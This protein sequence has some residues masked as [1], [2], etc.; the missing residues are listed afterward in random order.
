VTGINN[1]GAVVG[2]AFPPTDPTHEQ[3]LILIGSKYAFISRP[4]WSNT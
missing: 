2:G 4:G 3:G 1:S